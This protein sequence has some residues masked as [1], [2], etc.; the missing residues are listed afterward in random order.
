MHYRRVKEHGR[1]QLD[2]DYKE[3]VAARS[4]CGLYR[5]SVT[6]NADP[7]SLLRVRVLV[8]D[9]PGT[10]ALW[11]MPCVPAGTR[12][13]PEVGTQ[14]WVEFEAGNQDYPVWVGVIPNRKHVTPYTQRYGN[15]RG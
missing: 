3:N 13:V 12:S 11:A 7:E 10:E 8:P 6:D 2:T 14:V 15:V 5:G 4:L 1:V 9:V